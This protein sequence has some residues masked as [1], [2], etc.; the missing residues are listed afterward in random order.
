[1]K[2]GDTGTARVESL[3]HEGLGVA[4]VEGKAVFID[5]ALPGET[6]RFRVKKRRKSY[7]LGTTVEILETSPDRVAPRC[8]YFGVCGG[9]SFQHLR[10][11]AQLPVK[12]RV[13]RDN[14][15]RIGK[16]LPESW[17]PPLFGA[18]WAYRRKARLG[19]RL[20]WRRRAG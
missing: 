19:A 11:E 2:K 4:R 12:D 1:V 14:L 17:L 18:H 6:V 5:G 20:V 3:N 7:D 15:E 13:L 9:C 8:R 16:V 10:A